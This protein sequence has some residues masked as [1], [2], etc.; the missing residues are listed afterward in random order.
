[1]N[2]D[3]QREEEEREQKSRRRQLQFDLFSLENTQDDLERKQAI[4]A[5]EVKR[6]KTAI[7]KLEAELHDK[8]ADMVAIDRDVAR[9]NQEITHQ[10]KKMNAV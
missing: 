2:D 7:A 9:L 6:L 1:M 5:I 8:E 3:R 4:V 10:K